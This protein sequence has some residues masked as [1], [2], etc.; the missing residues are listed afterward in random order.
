M[1]T[2]KFAAKATI[3]GL[4]LAAS[5]IAVAPAA[6]ATRLGGPGGTTLE[7]ACYQIGMDAGSR[8]PTVLPPGATTR[9]RMQ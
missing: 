2:I 8:A 1:N 5:V 7:A 9:A 3:A 6:Q 4:A